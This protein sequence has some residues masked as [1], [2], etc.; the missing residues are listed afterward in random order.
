[1]TEEDLVFKREN[2][3]R[4]S[5]FIEN[6]GVEM[7]LLKVLKRNG[8]IVDFNRLKI[9]KAIVGAME[10]LGPEHINEGLAKRIARD[11]ER[12]ME[13]GVL[14]DGRNPS[15]TLSNPSGDNTSNT[16]TPIPIHAIEDRVE[17]KLMGSHCKDVARQY[18]RYRYQKKVDRDKYNQIKKKLK[19]I[20]KADDVQN[21]NANVDEYSF[22]GKK[23]EG[24]G[25]V[26]KD[27]A[28]TDY[29]SKDIAKAHNE[30]R[31]YIHDLDN[32]VSGMHNCSF[33]DMGK[34][35][36]DGFETRN[37]G[38][39]SP[40]SI[41]TAMQ[42]VAVIFQCQSQVQFGGVA[43]A[44]IDYD[45]APYVKKSFVKHFMDGLN[46]VEGCD[47]TQIKEIEMSNKQL[48]DN[49]HKAYQYAMEM[50]EK[51]CKQAAQALY[52]NLNTLQSRPGSQLPFSSINF[53]RDTSP[54]GRL[55]TKSLLE[56]SID[57]IGK[58]HRTSIFPISIF[59]HKKGV[60][61]Y[62]GDPNYDLK[63]L[64]LKSLGKR[65]YPNF[66]NCDFSE[67]IEDFNNPD[68]YNCT[69]GCRTAMSYDR[70]GFGY[71]KVGRGNVSPVTI[72]LPKIGIKHGICL[73]DRK[74][75][76]LDGFWIE[77]DEVLNLT[78]KALLERY[79]YICNQDP[80]GASF[81]YDNGT[82]RGFDGKSVESVMKH[83]SQ[84]IGMIGMA[85]TLQ[86]LFGKNQLDPD[87]RDFALKVVEHISDYA[88]EASERNDLNFGVYFT[89]AEGCCYTIC[90]KLKDEYG[91]IPNIT[92]KE[93][94]TN[95]IHVPVWENITAFEKIDIEATF[96]K[97]G[98][99]GCITY[100]EFDSK[101]I[102]N[103]QAVESVINYAME[104]NIPY[105]AINFP[106]D[107]CIDCHYQGD[108]PEEGCPICGSKN[109]ER[110][111]RVTGYLTSDVS[112]FNKG[113]QD[114]VRH[115]YKHMHE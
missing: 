59:Q 71:S 24:A 69:M 96:C 81:M 90:Q 28:L 105:F 37:G 93:F 73:G 50:T 64:A 41:S 87:A 26:F 98:T 42:L 76:D 103:L 32:Y 45:L 22:G 70:H 97:Y 10:D 67:N 100:V 77:L 53:G 102:N 57:G 12:E 86:A 51:E 9:E 88:K 108:I 113:K 101:I 11:I 54:E 107:T 33:V 89:P 109:I 65:I 35:L 21:S 14:F 56:A 114:E 110:L 83:G 63:Q 4:F 84:A 95:S 23:F 34:I 31:I 94:L 30:N 15:K 79:H 40:N 111:A 80:R 58:Y 18:I 82:M 61:A 66:V 78:E 47:N 38:V 48:A 112:H 85:E 91:I 16:L 49:H 29:I 99:S 3:Y 55:V 8:D 19:S 115:R 36:R 44:H 92:D 2:L 106:L 39:R 20:M 62:P 60:N 43:S 72:N 17:E 27:L 68:T 46:W 104:H 6:G 74:N 52:H 13:A 1:M 25:V 5:F 75:P 7:E